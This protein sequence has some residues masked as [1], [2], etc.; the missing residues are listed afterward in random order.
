MIT[1]S[2]GSTKVLE[3]AYAAA[4]P[5][6]PQCRPMMNAATCALQKKTA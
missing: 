5:V 2:T 6:I 4:T 1:V 3:I